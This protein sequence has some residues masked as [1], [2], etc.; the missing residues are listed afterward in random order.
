MLRLATMAN[1]ISLVSEAVKSRPSSRG[2]PM[3]RKYPGV[4]PRTRAMGLLAGAGRPS[5]TKVAAA[6]K[7]PSGKVSTAATARTPGIAARRSSTCCRNAIRR[8]GLALRSPARGRRKVKRPDGRNP[9]STLRK[10]A[11]LRISNVA[12]ISTSTASATSPTTRKLR[13]SRPERA[14][15]RPRPSSTNAEFSLAPEL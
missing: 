15:V 5:M 12:P 14:A 4:T 6:P 10:R 2:N 11:K 1:G 7:P 8:S 9:R 3:A 13:S